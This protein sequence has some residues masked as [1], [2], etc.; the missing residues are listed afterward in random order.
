MIPSTMPI[1]ISLIDG[2]CY[3]N[4]DGCTKKVCTEQTNIY[5]FFLIYLHKKIKIEYSNMNFG[6][7]Y[8][9]DFRIFEYS[10][11]SLIKSIHYNKTFA[12]L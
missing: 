2:S 10:V 6:F 1:I 12:F 3:A 9:A 11:P 7:E 5:I 8:S 4:K